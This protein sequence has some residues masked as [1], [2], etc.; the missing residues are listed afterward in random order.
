MKITV[1]H[2]PPESDTYR[3]ACVR[4]LFNADSAGV[5]IEADLP[6]EDRAW[7]LGVVVGPS[8]SGKST[9]GRAIWR[10]RAVY[11]P[12]RWPK[13]APIV[14]AIAPE[15]PF[16]AVTA[17]LAAVGLTVPWMVASRWP[18]PNSSPSGST[19]PFV[20]RSPG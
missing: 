15:Q 6:I 9:I 5:D 7:S 2:R 11:R 4:S 17:A 13:D 1:H 16:D 14:E 19:A 12:T 20:K 3:A 8:G 10:P 18:G